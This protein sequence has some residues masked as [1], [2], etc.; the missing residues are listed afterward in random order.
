MTTLEQYTV[1]REPDALIQAG[2]YHGWEKLPYEAWC[3]A[4]INRIYL[5]NP[6]RRLSL[7]RSGGKVALFEG[8]AT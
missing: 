3:I 4:E 8:R 1:Y 2:A 6:D 5:V 7:R